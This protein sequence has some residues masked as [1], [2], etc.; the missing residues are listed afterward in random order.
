LKRK[1]S[2]GSIKKRG[3]TG[4]AFQG[5]FSMEMF[6]FHLDEEE[7]VKSLLPNVRESPFSD[8]ILSIATSFRYGRLC[9]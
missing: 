1:K 5:H 6:I 7:I 3:W 4:W 9:V 2:P 8:K